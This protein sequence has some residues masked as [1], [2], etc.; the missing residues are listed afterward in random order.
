MKN[1]TYD[2]N[3]S[4]SL[5]KLSYSELLDL[6]EEIWESKTPKNP[7][8]VNP[9]NVTTGLHSHSKDNLEKFDSF[10][11]RIDSIKSD[12]SSNTNNNETKKDIYPKKS[13][14]SD[15]SDKSWVVITPEVNNYSK[16]SIKGKYLRM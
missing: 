16:I 9:L 13:I 11:S 15:K 5:N 7:V 10:N 1:L 4:L 6:L 2:E 8:K 3:L 12:T 14:F